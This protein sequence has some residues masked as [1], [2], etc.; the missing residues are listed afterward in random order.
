[1]DYCKKCG[2]EVKTSVTAQTAPDLCVECYRFQQWIPEIV[3]AVFD[4]PAPPRPSLT[5]MQEAMAGIA[6][7]TITIRR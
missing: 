7:P 3:K 6:K 1:M 4:T 2:V 5:Q